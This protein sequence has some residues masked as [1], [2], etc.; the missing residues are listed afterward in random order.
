M[1]LSTQADPE[2]IVSFTNWPQVDGDALARTESML[3]RACGEPDCS[4]TSLARAAF[5]AGGKRV[6]A[7]LALAAMRALGGELDA[8]AWAAACEMLHVASLVHDDI[9]DR[10]EL[11]RGQPAL[12]ASHGPAQAIAV[13]DL[14]L[15]LPWSVL[16]ELACSDTT[17]WRLVQALSRRATATARAQS[18]DI[19][20]NQSLII[21]ADSWYEA[22]EGKTGELLALPVEGAALLCGV[23]VEEAQILGDAIR[24]IGLA[25]QL[26]DDI[27]ELSVGSELTRGDLW[28]GRVNALIVAH[29][30]L[31]PDEQEWVVSCLRARTPAAVLSLA[32][33]LFGSGAVAMV[34]RRIDDVR[35]ELA[36]SA[37]LRRHP[38]LH[39]LALEFVE[40]TVMA[41]ARR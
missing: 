28:N 24:P 15:M 27:A 12:W 35:A 39:R 23:D 30:L 14:I 32:Y 31:W 10:D 16:A 3:L 41:R 34:R 40:R 5:A 21:R 1:Q 13:G 19:E 18:I 4:A 7:R 8:C 33:R 11:R 20:L 9:Q 26:W 22:A 6:R 25:Y 29:V 17:R 36:R 2:P 38:A 37:A